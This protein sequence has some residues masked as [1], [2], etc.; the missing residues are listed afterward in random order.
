MVSMRH[1]PPLHELEAEIMDEVWR[2]GECTVRDVLDALNG[3]SD[4]QRA[5]TTIMTVMHRLVG[6]GLLRRERR[7]RSDLFA[8]VITRDAY[9]D[10]RAGAEVDALVSAYGDVALAHFA[11]E[12]GRLDPGRR[13]QIRRLAGSE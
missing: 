2:S 12:I 1:P 11:R 5:Y 8:A 6:K 3:R 9:A 4:A 10:A 13:A 7:G